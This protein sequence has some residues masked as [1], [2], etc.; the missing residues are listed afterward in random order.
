[1]STNKIMV[2][3]T[4]KSNFLLIHAQRGRIGSDINSVNFRSISASLFLLLIIMGMGVST[5]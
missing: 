4:V 2:I 3:S 1:M 5:D